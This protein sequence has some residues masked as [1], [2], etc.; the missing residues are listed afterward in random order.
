MADAYKNAPI[1]ETVKRA[2]QTCRGLTG[3]AWEPVAMEE[4]RG[5]VIV[6]FTCGRCKTAKKDP[7]DKQGMVSHR[8]YR[9]AEGYQLHGGRVPR[10]EF[11]VEVLGWL[12]LKAPKV[13]KGVER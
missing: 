7:I 13:V 1:T 4:E 2:F 10:A 3:H 5:V 8:R 11:R 6:H 12:K 9:Y